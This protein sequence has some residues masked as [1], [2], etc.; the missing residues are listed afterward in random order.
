MSYSVCKPSVKSNEIQQSMVTPQSGVTVV[1][2]GEADKHQA[3]LGTP[4]SIRVGAALSN[5]RE[6]INKDNVFERSTDDY[7]KMKDSNE[8]VYENSNGRKSGNS[9][10]NEVVKNNS[11]E[12]YRS[13]SISKI[14]SNVSKNSLKPEANKIQTLFDGSNKQSY[15]KPNQIKKDNN[16]KHTIETNDGYKIEKENPLS[17]GSS[18]LKESLNM[19]SKGGYSGEKQLRKIKPKDKIGTKPSEN[20][21]SMKEK[22]RAPSP[23]RKSAIPI[24]T[25]PRHD[26]P[27]NIVIEGDDHD[28]IVNEDDENGDYILNELKD[29]GYTISAYITVIDS[30]DKKTLPYLDVIDRNG[31]RSIIEL[32]EKYSIEPLPEIKTFLIKSD[33]SAPIPFSLRDGAFKCAGLDCSGIAFISE[34]DISIL[35]KNIFTK[36]ITKN[37]Q[38]ITEIRYIAPG[39][40]SKKEDPI[41]YT[42]YPVQK[43]EEIFVDPDRIEKNNIQV[44]KRIWKSIFYNCNIELEKSKTS[45]DRF[46]QLFNKFKDDYIKAC[47]NIPKYLEELSYVA[48]QYQQNEDQILS[49]EDKENLKLVIYNLHR[50]NEHLMELTKLCRMVAMARTNL[51]IVNNTVRDAV[52][53]ISD[54]IKPDVKVLEIV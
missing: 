16:V 4:Q 18:E 3:K 22:L 45:L 35:K 40:L 53:Y 8:K 23:I 2:K 14:Q 42:P 11:P 48:D 54:E 21:N 24:E 5:Q 34:D 19:S 46:N 50:R 7:Q 36:P 30:G 17:K 43:I 1:A 47:D 12:S 28:L 51:E 25:L 41:E 6:K 39:H 31:Q 26:T 49:E 20:M 10:G 15:S 38:N 33:K 13:S 27:S 44:N 52:D 37:D 29:L 9:L 32:D